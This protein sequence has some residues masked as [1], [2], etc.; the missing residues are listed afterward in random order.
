[1]RPLSSLMVAAFWAATVQAGLFVEDFDSYDPGDYITQVS[2]FFVKW[3]PS[4]GPSADAQVTNEQ[5][6]SDSN[7]L[8]LQSTSKNGG[9]TDVVLKFTDSANWQAGRMTLSMRIYVAPG[10]GAY[11]NFQGDSAWGESYPVSVYFLASRRILIR[12]GS[13]TIYRGNY[14]QGQ[15]FTMA[16]DVDL[17]Y[18]QWKVYIDTANSSNPRVPSN[19]LVAFAN[20]INKLAGMDLYPIEPQTGQALYYIDD[21]EIFYQPHQPKNLDAAS[22]ALSLPSTTL[23][24]SQWPVLFTVRNIGDTTIHSIKATWHIGNTQGSHTFTNLNLAPLQTADLEFPLKVTLPSGNLTASVTIEQVNGG[25][26]DDTTNNTVSTPITAHA[27]AA[28]KKV[29][30]EE[31]TGT[32]CPWC[33]RGIVMMDRAV[34]HYNDFFV[35][36]A[37]HNNDPMAYDV[38]DQYV[39]NRVSGYPSVIIERDYIGDP[40][41]I[42]AELVARAQTAPPAKLTIENASIYNNQLSVTIQTEFL[43]NMSGPRLL[44]VVYEDSVT[45]TT[46]GYAQANAY[47]GGSNGPMGGYENKPNPVPASMMKYDLVSRH[48][49]GSVHGVDSFGGSGTAGQVVTTTFFLDSIPGEWRPEKLRVAVALLKS[50]GKVVNANKAE[51]RMTPAGIGPVSD[52]FGASGIYPNPTPAG[53]A[54]YAGITLAGRRTLAMTI[55]DVAG[56]AMY[57]QAFAAAAG[58]VYLPLPSLL[59]AGTY[60]VLLTTDRGERLALQWQVVR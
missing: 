1:M 18:N 24:G 3:D 31:A 41:D 9:P 29:W 28:H 33:V 2:P 4:A 40:L 43:A 7:S 44:V 51:V 26:D 10:K 8:K 54:A 39:S 36:I 6:Y 47:A 59:N 22:L 53:S 11:Y 56:K 15:W 34:E 57:R 32:W 14:P 35:G 46:R 58:E 42:E 48:I 30:V 5:F 16:W 21:I 49:F 55:Y 50:D 13:G 20:P 45:G 12:S 23:G 17:T 52:V 27:P 19:L 37:V 60:H 25:A 38:H